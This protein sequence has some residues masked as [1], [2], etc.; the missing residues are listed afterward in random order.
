MMVIDPITGEKAKFTSKNSIIEIYKEK[1]VIE[2]KVL[3]SK[4]DRLDNNNI[5]KFY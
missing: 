5:L 1:N 2:G 3:Y 4:N